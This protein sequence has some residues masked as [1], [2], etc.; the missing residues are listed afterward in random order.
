MAAEARDPDE[1]FEIGIAAEQEPTVCGIGTKAGT[2]DRQAD[3]REGRKSPGELIAEQ[4]LARRIGLGVARG[5][6]ALVTRTEQKPTT[7]GPEI[8]IYV[9]M[10]DEGPGGIDDR[11]GSRQVDVAKERLERPLPHARQHTDGAPPT[12][13]RR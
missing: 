12:L 9:V 7:L 2:H 6:G 13:R 10:P 8:D 3:A 11:I 5:L 4:R 1:P